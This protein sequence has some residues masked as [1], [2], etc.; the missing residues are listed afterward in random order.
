MK[1]H[2]EIRWLVALVTLTFALRSVFGWV[3]GAEFGALD[4]VLTKLLTIVLDVNLVLGLILL[5]G[6][7]GGFPA[8]RVE[9]A[10]TMVLAV[11]TAHLTAI[12]R[13]SED[14]SRIF[15]NNFI[16]AVVVL[17]LVATG[18]M[19]LRGNWIF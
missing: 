6:L 18:V 8:Y 15:R 5:F 14:A 10:V 3:R 7:P 16:V 1:I 2:G 9:H 13:R 19:R 17:V 4:R 11:A 12:W